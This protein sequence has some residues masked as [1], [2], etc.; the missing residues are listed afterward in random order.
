MAD[1]IMQVMYDMRKSMH[2]RVYLSFLIECVGIG[3]LDDNDDDCNDESA[4]V[5]NNENKEEKDGAS[6][7]DNGEE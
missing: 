5:N 7:N 2:M 4:D 3:G 6:I 1:Y